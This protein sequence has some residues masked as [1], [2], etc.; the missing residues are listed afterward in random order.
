MDPYLLWEGGQKKGPHDPKSIFRALTRASGLNRGRMVPGR[1]NY[2][3]LVKYGLDA[4]AQFWFCR[5]VQ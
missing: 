3:I 5:M 4:L 1:H 2:T